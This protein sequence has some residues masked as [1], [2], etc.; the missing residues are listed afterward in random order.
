MDHVIDLTIC[1]DNAAFGDTYAEQAEELARI[2]RVLADRLVASPFYLDPTSGVL[3]SIH[4]ING[5]RVGSLTPSV[6]ALG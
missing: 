3:L 6:L 2:F 1:V 5:N 4:D